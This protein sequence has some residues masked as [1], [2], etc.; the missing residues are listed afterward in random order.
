MSLSRR[1]LLQGAALTGLGARPATVEVAAIE[2]GG[3]ALARR[4]TAELAKG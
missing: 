1:A 4:L 2:P 3:R